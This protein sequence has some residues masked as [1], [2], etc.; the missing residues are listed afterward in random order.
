MR[1]ST[2]SPSTDSRVCSTMTLVPARPRRRFSKR[3]ARSISR[4][5]VFRGRDRRSRRHSSCTGSFRE[6]LGR[7]RLSAPSRATIVPGPL[8]GFPVRASSFGARCSRSSAVWTK[9]SSCTARTRIFV[10]A[11][12]RSATKFATSRSDRHPPGRCVGSSRKLAAGHGG[13]PDPIC[14]QAS[15]PPAALLE[16]AA[17]GLLALTHV[18]VSRGGRRRRAGHSLAL[19][20]ALGLRT[21]AIR[22]D[23]RL[24]SRP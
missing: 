5:G 12:G 14:T 6:L 13:E 17:V 24:P 20:V 7:T 8:T 16:R 4:S 19:L 11:S 10:V 22:L 21:P 1:P 3:T 9:V 18:I 23:R 15:R 2:W